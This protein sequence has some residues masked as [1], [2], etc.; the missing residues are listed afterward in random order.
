M[1]HIG[2]LH[3]IKFIFILNMIKE[4]LFSNIKI[5][6]KKILI[7]MLITENMKEVYACVRS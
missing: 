7:I 6:K 5:E 3:S 2:I 1:Y 4:E